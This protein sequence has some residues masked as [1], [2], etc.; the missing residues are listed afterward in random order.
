MKRLWYIVSALKNLLIITVGA[1][2]GFKIVNQTYD[3][4][5][6]VYFLIG[7]FGFTILTWWEESMKNA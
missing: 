7:L 1:V 5:S 6:V 2:L 3:I 4:Q